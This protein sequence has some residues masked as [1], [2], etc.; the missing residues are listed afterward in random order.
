MRN[1]NSM[2]GGGKLTIAT[3]LQSLRDK[4]AYWE[5]VW[6]F[7]ALF[8]GLVTRSVTYGPVL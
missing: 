1:Q 3:D 8:Y 2:K 7:L 5:T 6:S 4:Y